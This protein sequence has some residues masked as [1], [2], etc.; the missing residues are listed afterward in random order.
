[1]IPR[2][3]LRRHTSE[4]ELHIQAGTLADLLAEA[5]KALAEVQ[6]AGADCAQGG[7]ARAIRV[8]SSDREALLVDWLNELI[9]LA[10]LDRWV[11]MEFEIGHA[12]NT[13][14]RARASGVILDWAPSRAKAATMHGLRVKD[15]P[16]GLEAS[17][18]IDV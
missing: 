15:L 7:P 5:G 16:G 17:V 2:H 18:I 1:M 3:E 12:E 6:L 10:D 4:I 8:S 11:A 9:F 13:E 14:V